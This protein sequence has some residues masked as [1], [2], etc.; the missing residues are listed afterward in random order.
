MDCCTSPALPS[1]RSLAHGL[2]CIETLQSPIQ[3][4]AFAGARLKKVDA[5]NSGNRTGNAHQSSGCQA[6]ERMSAT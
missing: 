3:Y 1:L 6:F 2:A 4:C 5:D